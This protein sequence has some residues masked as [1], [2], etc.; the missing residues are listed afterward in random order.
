MKPA[1]KSRDPRQGIGLW[2]PHA[3]ILLLLLLACL[4]LAEVLE[5]VLSVLLLGAA[6]AALSYPLLCGPLQGWAARR[7]PA[8]ASSRRRRW[9]AA[10]TIALLALGPLLPLGLLLWNSASSLD[11]T[12]AVWM[13]LLEKNINHLEG[14]IQQLNDELDVLRS[15]YPSFPIEPEWV[16]AYLRE[17]LG[18]LLQLQPS[19]MAFLLKGTG[20]FVA[21]LLL[22]FMAVFFFYAEG[23][24]LVGDILKATPLR[25]EV[26]EGLK[27]NFVHYTLSF[28]LSSFGHALLTGTGLGLLVGAF[29]RISPTVIILFSAFICLLPLVGNTLIWLP[30]ATLLYQR[31]SLGMALL[32]VLFCQVVIWGSTALSKRWSRRLQEPSVLTRFLLFLSIVGGLVRFGLKGIIMGPAAVILVTVMAKCWSDYYSPIKK[33]S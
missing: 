25:G 23:S 2:M 29:L 26:G 20:S 27:R 16:K 12:G 13:G 10:L 32:F 9:V 7:F 31:G 1:F 14:L 3:F 21:Q 24:S 33:G 15:L 4:F 28:L 17:S 5:P 18:G 11:L 6:I 30:A 22:C 19:L 8:V